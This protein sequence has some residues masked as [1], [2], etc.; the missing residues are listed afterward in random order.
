M[1]IITVAARN[2]SPLFKRQKFAEGLPLS[3]I[4]ARATNGTRIGYSQ[5]ATGGNC[6]NGLN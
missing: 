3:H 6:G 5:S 1:H 4:L 2:P